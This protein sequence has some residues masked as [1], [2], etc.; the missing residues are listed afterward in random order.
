[1]PI[2]ILP[3]FFDFKAA[4]RGVWLINRKISKLLFAVNQQT[5]PNRTQII[6][7]NIRKVLTMRSI[8]T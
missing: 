8:K 7:E 1:M 2:I 3:L 5:L 4:E 6:I